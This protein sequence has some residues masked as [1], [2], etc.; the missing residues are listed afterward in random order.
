M[1]PA[2]GGWKT[3]ELYT[4]PQVQTSVWYIDRLLVFGSQFRSRLMGNGPTVCH[5]PHVILSYSHSGVLVLVESLICWSRKLNRI[6]WVTPSLL[7]SRIIFQS[8]LQSTLPLFSASVEMNFHSSS[9]ESSQIS[10]IISKQIQF[11]SSYNSIF[12]ATYFY[13]CINL[14]LLI[15][16]RYFSSYVIMGQDAIWEKTEFKIKLI[17]LEIRKI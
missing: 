3:A 11:F 4:P 9:L 13:I 14:G 12:C 8:H 15:T 1:I 5:L 2:L 6:L 17:H 7:G 16:L 10:I